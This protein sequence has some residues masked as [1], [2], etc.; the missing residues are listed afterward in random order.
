VIFSASIFEWWHGNGIGSS[1]SSNDFVI[2]FTGLEKNHFATVGF[3]GYPSSEARFDYTKLIAANNLVQEYIGNNNL[4]PL[5]ERP[6][7]ALF[8]KIFLMTKEKWSSEGW[9]WVC[10]RMLSLAC[11]FG[12]NS[13]LPSLANFLADDFVNA[14]NGIERTASKAI[15]AL[16]VITKQDFRYEKEGAS[17]SIAIVA[18]EYLDYLGVISK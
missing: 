5:Y 6:D 8:S 13:I 10:E 4:K 16:A 18:K 9:W 17:K 12:D 7:L 2:S 15:N 14:K 11:D 3:C 1:W